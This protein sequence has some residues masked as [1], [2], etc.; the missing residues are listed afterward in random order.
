MELTSPGF[1]VFAAVGV[2]AFHAAP[3]PFWR[4]LVLTLLNTAFLSTFVARLG[5]LIPLVLFIGSAY[6]AV[7]LV[8]RHKGRWL[9]VTLVVLLVFG[10]AYLKQYAFLGFLPPLRMTYVTVGLSYIVF[11]CLHLLIDTYQYDEP[12]DDLEP[13]TAY[14]YLTGFLSL[15]AGP[16]QRYEEYRQQERAGTAD[17]GV[18][19]AGGLA[20][21]GRL[22]QGL[23][24]V[25]IIGSFL[26]DLHLSW[27]GAPGLPAHALAAA[28]FCH[29]AFVYVN[30]S[31]YMDVVIGLGRLM[32]FALPENFNAPYLAGN[33]LNLWGRWHITL[34]EWFKTYV[35]NPLLRVLTTWVTSRAMMP[36]LAAAAY[37]VVFFLLGVWHGTNYLYVVLGVCLGLGVSVNK[38][39]DVELTRLLGRAGRQRL[40]GNLLY[41]SLARGM[42]LAYFVMAAVASWDFASVADLARFAADVGWLKLAGSYGLLVAAIGGTS[43]VVTVLGRAAGGMWAAEPA[44]WAP[45]ARYAVISFQAAC[46]ALFLLPAPGSPPAPDE[47]A[48]PIKSTAVFYGQF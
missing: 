6:G 10:F 14:N 2:F 42:A 16:I 41:A 13:W 40:A 31:G 17:P 38:L 39:W 45:W 48:A 20:A 8:N 12:R 29:L 28:A 35:F 32:G 43:L 36:Y 21:L 47:T 25:A 18:T 15:T 5:E 1:L 37:F 11:R 23:F 26:H 7:L 3:T 34:S 22:A 19:S 44:R 4:K 27:R 30:F 46:V 33:F 24:K 9:F